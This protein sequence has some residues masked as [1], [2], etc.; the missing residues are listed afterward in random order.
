MFI[1]SLKLSAYRRRLHHPKLGSTVLFYEELFN[2]L[3]ALSCVDIHH[4]KEAA[5]GFGIRQRIGVLA[6]RTLVPGNLFGARGYN[7]HR[8]SGNT[9][10][11][12]RFV[13]Y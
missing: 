11:L 2:I 10:P 9:T 1:K 12:R 8:V 7:M 13:V 4:D 6:S 3:T 5:T